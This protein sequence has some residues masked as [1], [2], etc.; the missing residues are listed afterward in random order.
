MTTV[1]FTLE[2]ERFRLA[3]R[4]SVPEGPVRVGDLLP[5]A[6][7]LADGVVA[8]TCRALEA[9]GEK[10]SCTKGCGACCRNLVAISEVEARQIRALVDRLPEPRREAIRARFR[11]ARALLRKAGLLDALL[12]PERMTAEEYG[13]MVGLYF[14]EGIPCPFL[15]DDSCSI[16]EERP[17]TCREFLVTSPPEHCAE[18]GSKDVRR[19]NLPVRV[20]NA[21][22]RWQVPPAEHVEERWVPL[23]LA[24]EW[25]AAHPD[26]P[27]PKPG[28]ELL[29]DLL[30]HVAGGPKD[31]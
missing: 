9:A 15:E 20:F 3:G 27:A 6:R 30:G 14:R 29:R 8:E 16:Y 2:G 11:E 26:E 7:A 1:D 25:A 18:L 17:V 21:V 28:P 22:A 13:K 24:P 4:V 5:V 23:I 12:A 31:G 19:V 10:I